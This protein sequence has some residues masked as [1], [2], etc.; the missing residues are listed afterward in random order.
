MKSEVWSRATEKYRVDDD[1]PA[2]KTI[3][4]PATA[5]KR[6]QPRHTWKP[7][8]TGAYYLPACAACKMQHHHKPGCPLAEL[9]VLGR[10]EKPK[11][12]PLCDE[13][14]CTADSEWFQEHGP[15]NPERP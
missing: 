15:D 13:L 11:T 10:R 6:K 2:R 14:V 8:G 9:M 3:P 7:A 1:R 4:E 5:K 12:R